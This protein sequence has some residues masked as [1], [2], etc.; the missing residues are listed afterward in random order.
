MLPTTK[1]RPALSL[2]VLAIEEILLEE[3]ISTNASKVH[4]MRRGVKEGRRVVSTVS[5][6]EFLLEFCLSRIFYWPLGVSPPF[7]GNPKTPDDFLLLY[8]KF[9]SKKYRKC[10]RDFSN[11]D[12]AFFARSDHFPQMGESCKDQTVISCG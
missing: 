11:Q 1:D 5:G 3:A 10:G 2:L 7:G 9:G 6:I 8:R 12:P 4:A